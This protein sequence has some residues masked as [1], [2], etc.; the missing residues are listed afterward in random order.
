VE[1]GPAGINVKDLETIH[2]FQSLDNSETTS[3]GTTSFSLEYFNHGGRETLFSDVSLVI[4]ALREHYSPIVPTRLGLRYVNIIQRQQVE[5]DLQRKLDWSD[6]LSSGFSSVPNGIA[7]VDN[8]TSYVVEISSPCPC[9]KMTV[10]YGVL[11]EGL[12]GVKGQHFRLDTDRFLDTDLKLDDVPNILEVFSL[13][14]FNVFMQA[15]GSALV[16]WMGRGTD[17]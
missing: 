10:R 2:K 5:E 12:N 11:P 17:A 13:D 9:G 14:I 8:E 1:I 16:E 3:L 6:L 7:N 4:G 15:A